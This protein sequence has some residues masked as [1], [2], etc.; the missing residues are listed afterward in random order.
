MTLLQ[1]G[2]QSVWMIRFRP[3]QWWRWGMPSLR[4]VGTTLRES[5]IHGNESV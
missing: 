5:A 1:V 2:G 3:S 4:D